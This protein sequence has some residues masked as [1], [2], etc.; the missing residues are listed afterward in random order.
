MDASFRVWA[1]K[2]LTSLHDM[3]EGNT[4][5]SFDQLVVKC[6]VPR[7]DFFRHLQLRDF[8]KKDATLLI[9]QDISAEAWKNAG[10]LSICIKV[11]AMQLKLLHRAHISPSRRHKFKNDCSPVCLKCKTEEGNLAHCFWFC[12]EIQKCWIIVEKELNII[13]SI[14]IGRDPKYLLLGTSVEMI[15]DK[16]KKTNF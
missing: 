7:Q 11:K 6:S 5:M 1:H 14:N 15:L 9:N 8:V 16:H 10:T 13:L 12:R 3:F 2:D 4:L